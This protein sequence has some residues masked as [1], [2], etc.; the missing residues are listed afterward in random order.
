MDIIIFFLYFSVKNSDEKSKKA[1]SDAARLADELRTEQV[2]Y[3]SICMSIYLSVNI[4]K[5]AVSDAARLADE[6]R[7]EQV[8]YLSICMSIICLFIQIYIR[9]Q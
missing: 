4:Y 5:K 3:L 1:V 8:R 7:T 2:S 6:L 9:R